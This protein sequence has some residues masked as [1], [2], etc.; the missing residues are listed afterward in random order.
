MIKLKILSGTGYPVLSG[1]LTIITK[2]TVR[3]RQNGQSQR[4]QCNKESRGREYVMI[5]QRSE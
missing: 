4:R 1:R 5:K 2:V 3:E